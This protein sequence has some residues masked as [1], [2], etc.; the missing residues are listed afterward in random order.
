M[1]PDVFKAA[2]ESLKRQ[3]AKEE[4]NKRLAALKHQEQHVQSEQLLISQSREIVFKALIANKNYVTLPLQVPSSFIVE[5]EKNGIWLSCP[6]NI[7]WDKE[8]DRGG[9]M[10]FGPAAGAKV[11]SVSYSM[12][13]TRPPSP[14]YNY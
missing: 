3:Q 9:G 6:T 7:R 12:S 11:V 13:R 10:G 8:D 4:E 14:E 5:M 2:L 1:N